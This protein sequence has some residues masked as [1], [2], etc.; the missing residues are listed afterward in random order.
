MGIN[1]IPVR[2][3]SLF[4]RNAKVHIGTGRGNMG[5]FIDLTGQKFGR[6]TVL[7]EAGIDKHGKVK[8]LCRCECGT[9][10]AI[11]GTNLRRGVIVS[12]GCLSRELLDKRNHKHGMYGAP[13]H[14]AWKVM[15]RRCREINFISYKDYGGR[16]ITVCERWDKFENFYAD[17][18]DRPEGL[19]IERIDN[20]GNYELANCKW[21]TQ[22][23]QCRNKRNNR[24]IKYGGESKCVSAWAEEL[25]INKNTLRDRLNRYPPQL[26]F[27]M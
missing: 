25:G 18:G 5:K 11:D 3:K 12:C 17:M 13:I 7:S 10:K 16:G 6:L 15:R 22:K 19:S 2:R 21:A 24:V 27:N 1:G 26:A 9:Q 4:V 23:E 14:N 20:N 8:W